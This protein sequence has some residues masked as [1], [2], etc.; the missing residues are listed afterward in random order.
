M[1]VKRTLGSLSNTLLKGAKKTKIWLPG[2]LVRGQQRQ[3]SESQLYQA[4][5][6]DET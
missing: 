4:D 5:S 1:E 6:G 2:C 3:H